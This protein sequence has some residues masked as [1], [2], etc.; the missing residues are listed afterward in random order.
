MFFIGIIYSSVALFISIQIFEKMAGLM[1]VFLTVMASIPLMYRTIKLEEQK[2]TMGLKEK[3]LLREHSR[4]L[5]FFVFLFLGVLASFTL[6]YVFL[7]ENMLFSLFQVQIETIKNINTN[8]IVG[9]AHAPSIFMKIF[10]NNIKVLTFCILFAFFYGA[11]AI[12]ILTWNASVI[13]TAMGTFIRNNMAHYANVAG[14]PKI[15]AFLQIFS[16]SILRYL[17]HGVPE[18]LAYFVGGL[19]GGIISIAI[20]R[21][22]FRTKNFEKILLDTSVLIIAAIILLFIAAL[23]EVY[24]T[25][26]LF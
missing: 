23:L 5:A 16:L 19:A 13:S 3:T 12:F 9:A 22:D 15:A 11:G 7:P 25:P 24:V 21:Q 1:S 8:V 6:W 18:I 20:I 17:V 14:L 26:L 2:D 4:A 10:L